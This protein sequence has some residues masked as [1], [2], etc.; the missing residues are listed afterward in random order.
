MLR[1]F[2]MQNGDRCGVGRGDGGIRGFTPKVS[3]FMPFP[4]QERLQMRAHSNFLSVIIV[5]S[6]QKE[7]LHQYISKIKKSL[8]LISTH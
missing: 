3:G 8:K 7:T 6:R 4:S 2:M 5:Y 1:S